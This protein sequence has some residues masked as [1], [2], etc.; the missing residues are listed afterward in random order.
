MYNIRNIKSMKTNF[1]KFQNPAKATII[2]L[3]TFLMGISQSFAQSFKLSGVSDMVRVFEDGYKLPQMYDSVNIFGIRGEIVSGQF[4][5]SA[6]KDLSG[7]TVES[8]DFKRGLTGNSL[9]ASTIEWNFVGSIPLEKN[10]PNQPVTALI[11]EAPARF[12]DYLMRDRQIDV[13]KKTVQSVWITIKIPETALP[14][15][16]LGKITVRTG[17]ETQSLPLT[18][19]IYPLNMPVERHINVVEWY[20]TG[21]FSRFHGIKEEYS[22][23]WFDMLRN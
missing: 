14:G 20:S 6:K 8:G 7:V 1:R 9:L 21:G 17:Q 23:E 18:L 15:T 13:K 16:Y 11:R 12:P 19:E 4:I 22:P 2:C 10:T 5:I 3:A